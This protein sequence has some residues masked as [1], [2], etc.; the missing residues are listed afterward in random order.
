MLILLYTPERKVFLGF[1]PNDQVA[2]VDRLKKVIQHQK[3]NLALSKNQGVA[4]AAAAGT[5]SA[6]GGN[7]PPP[8]PQQQQQQQQQSLVMPQA[9][10]MAMAGGQITQ[11]IVTSSASPVGMGGLLG[12]TM[13]Q[14]TMRMHVSDMKMRF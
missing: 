7:P 11:N 10:A 2:F 8:P 13:R 14:N 1:I 9:N 5:S 6:G 12:Q 4:A 3:T